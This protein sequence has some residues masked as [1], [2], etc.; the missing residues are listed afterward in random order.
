[1]ASG[2]L[3]EPELHNARVKIIEVD[4]PENGIYVPVGLDYKTGR[5]KEN[6]ITQL[7]LRV[8]RLKDARYERE[9]AKL[10]GTRNERAETDLSGIVMVDQR[11]FS[12]PSP[13]YYFMRFDESPSSPNGFAPFILRLYF[14]DLEEIYVADESSLRISKK[15]DITEMFEQ[16]IGKAAERIQEDEEEQARAERVKKSIEHWKSKHS[17]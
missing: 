14:E 7:N 4:F 12:R 1:M 6:L 10:K 16:F 2:L 9:R 15:Y 13:C 3:N 11:E 17:L 8:A 5:E